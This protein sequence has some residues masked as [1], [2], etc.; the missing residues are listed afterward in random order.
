MD[1]V[2]EVDKVFFTESFKGTRT[3]NMLRKSHK[4]VKRLKRGI[5]L[6]SKFGR[7]SFR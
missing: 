3:G 6:R 1:G 7:Y 2:I 5:Y 4:K